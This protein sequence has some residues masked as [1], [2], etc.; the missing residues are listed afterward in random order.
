M[1]DVSRRSFLGGA[2]VGA[3]AGTMILGTSKTGWAQANEKVRVA[4]LGVRGRG[5]DHLGGWQGLQNVEV[6]T[7]CDIDENLFEGTLKKFFDEKNLPRP[8]VETD[9]RKVFE[10]PNV[11]AVSI[12]IPNHW[13]SLAAIWAIQAGKDV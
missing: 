8:K 11:D 2:A 3:A 6:V 7:I 9:M 13:H 1:S 10:D 12:A 5:R 4:V